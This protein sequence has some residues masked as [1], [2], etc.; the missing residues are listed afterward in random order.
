MG[1]VSPT[2]GLERT[3]YH[4]ARLLVLPAK[5]R[6]LDPHPLNQM[7]NLFPKSQQTKLSPHGTSH[8]G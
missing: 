4:H 5:H 6:R 7:S 3:Q 8:K 2:T 1:M